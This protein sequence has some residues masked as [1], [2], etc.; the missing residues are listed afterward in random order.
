MIQ[1]G[2]RSYKTIE[3]PEAEEM[4]KLISLLSAIGYTLE[5]QA[6]QDHYVGCETKEQTARKRKVSAR[7]IY[8]RLK[9]GRTWLEGRMSDFGGDD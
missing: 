1:G 3:N 7:T 5:A 6:L 8:D 2:G 9:S 4:D